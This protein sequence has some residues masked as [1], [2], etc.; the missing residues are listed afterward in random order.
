[1]SVHVYNICNIEILLLYKNK[2]QSAHPDVS[3][4]LPKSKPYQYI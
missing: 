3:L 4:G 2:L 1:M